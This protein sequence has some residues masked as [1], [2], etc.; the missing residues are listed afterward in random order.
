MHKQTT[1]I[2]DPHLSQKINGQYLLGNAT[3]RSPE[4]A[5]LIG[6]TE[7][8]LIAVARLRLCFERLAP[9]TSPDSASQTV[10]H[11]TRHKTF[12]CRPLSGGMFIQVGQ[13]SKDLILH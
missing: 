11:Y 3:V 8:R 5:S 2:A 4:L 6:D 1:L 13:L 12:T 7:S 10:V 9:T